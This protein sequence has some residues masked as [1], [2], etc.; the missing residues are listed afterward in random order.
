MSHKKNTL[1]AMTIFT[2]GLSAS[3]LFGQ[4]V[5]PFTKRASGSNG[6]FVLTVEANRLSLEAQDA[7]LRG[8]LEEIG[9]KMHIEVLGEIPAK[10]TITAKF[11]NL[12]LEEALQRLS[13]NFGYQMKSE[14]GGQEIVKIFVLPKGTGTNMR[15]TMKEVEPSKEIVTPISDPNLQA[16]GA[17]EN[18][19][20]QEKP[21][22]PAPFK[23]EFDPSA[24]GE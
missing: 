14:E 7:S 9:R 13:S 10:E 6:N 12:P 3:V 4:G 15:S 1:L 19:S 2:L 5:D 22:R 17:K 20:D 24:F 23:F 11:H 21:M 16:E 8:I 18:E